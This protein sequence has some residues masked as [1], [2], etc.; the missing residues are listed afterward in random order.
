MSVDEG[1][2]G[3]VALLLALDVLVCRV[4]ALHGGQS[5]NDHGDDGER[6]GAV[7]LNAKNAPALWVV[8]GWTKAVGGLRGGGLGMAVMAVMAVVGNKFLFFHQKRQRCE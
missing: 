5:D 4:R 1:N 7:T 2:N 3:G 6:R 8:S